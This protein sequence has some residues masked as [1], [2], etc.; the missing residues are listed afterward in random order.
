[1]SALPLEGRPGVLRLYQGMGPN[2]YRVRIFMAERG[3]ADVEMVEVRLDQGEH[4]TEA[5]RTL[6]S[7]GRIPVLVLP[8]GTAISESVA[9]C[10]Y[11]DETRDGTPLFGAE[12]VG[13]A[14]VEMWNRRLELEILATIGNVALHSD[15]LFAERLVQ[16]PAFADAERAAVAARWNWLDAEM[17]DGRAFVA[18]ETFSAAD[19]TGMVASWLGDILGIGIPETARHVRRWDERMRARPSWNA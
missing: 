13:R 1:M 5:F 10:R 2:S 3:I 9:I 15:P 16:F 14:A 8:D 18:G 6:N 17:S 7:I 11:L 19:A 12:P 4:K